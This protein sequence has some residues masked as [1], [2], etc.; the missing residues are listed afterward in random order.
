M[1]NEILIEDLDTVIGLTADK[2]FVRIG[3]NTKHLMSVLLDEI[4]VS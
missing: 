4:D 3:P 1:I 2:P